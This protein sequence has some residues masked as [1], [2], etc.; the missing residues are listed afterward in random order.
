[1]KKTTKKT[2]KKATKIMIIALLSV[3]LSC[4]S[5][6]GLA[7]SLDNQ[8]YFGSLEISGLLGSN[9]VFN[10]TKNNFTV[11]ETVVVAEKTTSITAKFSSDTDV[12]LAYGSSNIT[13]SG[14]SISIPSN[15]LIRMDIS[16]TVGDQQFNGTY[17]L[18][19]VKASTKLDNLS[20]EL[21]DKTAVSFTESFSTSKLIYVTK[22]I[23]NDIES[24][25]LVVEPA[26]E[27]AS[28]SVDGKI[29]TNSNSYACTIDIPKGKN[30][31]IAVD[32]SYTNM[33]TN[34]YRVEIERMDGS[35]STLKKLELSTGTLSPSFKSA[36]K[37]YSAQYSSSTSKVT[38]TTE[39]TD[40]G[41]SL[42]YT[43]NDNALSSLKD[44]PLE[45]GENTLKIT[46]LPF[47]GLSVDRS[48]YTLTLNRADSADEKNAYLEALSISPS[49]G[50][51]SWSKSFDKDTLSYTIN[52]DDDAKNVRI[53][54]TVEAKGAEISITAGSSTTD[55]SEGSGSYSDSI[56]VPTGTSGVTVKVKVTPPDGKST[57]KTY[58]LKITRDAS[59]SSSSALKNLVVKGGSTSYKLMP[60][61]D[62][63][64]TEYYVCVP[65]GVEDITI[66]PTANNTNSTITVNG[67][68][69][70]SGKVSEE[71]SVST[72]SSGRSYSVKI[73][74]DSGS[75]R[76]Y[77]VNVYSSSY[78]NDSGEKTL[79]NLVVRTGTSSSSTQTAT[80]SPQ[81][82]KATKSYEIGVLS[83]H[84]Y[85][86]FK[87]ASTNS[88]SLMFVYGTSGSANLKDDTTSSRF[89]LET[90]TN[91]FTIRVYNSS[92]NSYEEYKIKVTRK[93]DSSENTL[94]SVTLKDNN[95]K[96]LT[97]SPA[98]NRDTFT[99]IATVESDITGV[100]VN[101]L[102]R[103]DES[104]MRVNGV[105]LE[106]N[107]DSSL[108]DIQKGANTITLNVTAADGD[109]QRY[110][111]TIYCGIPAPVA[112]FTMRL[113]LGSKKMTVN[114]TEK[115]LD[116]APFTYNSRTMVP[117]RFVSEYLG[118]TVD[119]DEKT[120][121][122]TIKFEDKTLQLV[123][124]KANSAIGLDV[125]PMAYNNRT[126]VPI[127]Y[128]SEQ[129]G[130]TV[131]WIEETNE[132]TI[133]KN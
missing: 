49:T 47:N 71:L 130:A 26:F 118:A 39:T 34:Y 16:R 41:A 121:T 89:R 74:P 108:I 125:P 20:L 95:N 17:V 93:N 103:D 116:V 117:I 11:T 72:S 127:R 19:V 1:M 98:F 8:D 82:A 90:G 88:R 65:N 84:S 12:K 75:S 62:E 45:V 80:L 52:I 63:S 107:K 4:L 10:L 94:S 29:L 85:I 104:T 14:K 133:T 13:S 35:E 21:L 114:G 5:L 56:S 28:I 109:V 122:V 43:L 111:F 50:S 79:D 91:D 100:K 115:T 55:Y 105:K 25:V 101:A 37:S 60:S 132:I 73:T 123:Q 68:R 119:W 131:H 51:A 86:D 40:K 30:K 38:I 120:K 78:T 113:Q 53:R 9:Q 46:V 99:Y 76:T 58:T 87:A 3:I 59:T 112:D 97:L 81:F 102:P 32:V 96:T 110:T 42:S 106:S 61:F 66:T 24:I 23:E 64:I 126:M 124:G 6:G 70:E 128:V 15:G 48:I 31:T 22:P 83:D 33:Q 36:T 18:K 44:I 69:V 57:A 67:D 77:T 92:A 129:L 2:T 7:L 27:L 54:P